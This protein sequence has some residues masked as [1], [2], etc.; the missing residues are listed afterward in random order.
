M[1][2]KRNVYFSAVDQET[3]E[4]RLFS[5]NEIMTEEEYLERMYSETK[6]KKEKK[7]KMSGKKKAAI[8][9]TAA[10]VGAGAVVGGKKYGR[11]LETAGAKVL[12]NAHVN[13]G[14]LGEAVNKSKV[15]VGKVMQAPADFI[16]KGVGKAANSKTGMK[17]R[18]YLSEAAL[19]AEE[20]AYKA[21]DKLAK[22]KK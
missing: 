19:K 20:A 17:V 11:A 1:L 22:S 3:G 6:E 2:I 7:E 8:A 12:N 14:K 5:V 18:G 9:G 21:K 4:E 10:L 15:T 13:P 16:T